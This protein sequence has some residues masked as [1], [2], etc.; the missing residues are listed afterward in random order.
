MNLIYTFFHYL[1][2][3]SRNK[4]VLVV[5]YVGKLHVSRLYVAVFALFGYDCV[6]GEWLGFTINSHS[7]Y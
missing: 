2:D 4:T 1:C 6:C 7:W 3:K 5:K